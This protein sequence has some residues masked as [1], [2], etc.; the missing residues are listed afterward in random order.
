MASTDHTRSRMEA[1][2]AMVHT[3][4]PPHEAQ[5]TS[6]LAAT[7]LGSLEALNVRSTVPG[8]RQ[9]SSGRRARLFYSSLLLVGASDGTCGPEILTV[10]EEMVDEDV[11]VSTLEVSATVGVNAWE[12]G[13]VTKS[14]EVLTGW[15]GGVQKFWGPRAV[16]T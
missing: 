4:R 8:C 16:A 6:T 9:C 2:Q 7:L 11:L 3:H 13:K 14:E 5:Q 10:D 1:P 12:K 15:G